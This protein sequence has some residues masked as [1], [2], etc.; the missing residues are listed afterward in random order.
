VTAAFDGWP[1]KLAQVAISADDP[2]AATLAEN[3]AHVSTASAVHWTLGVLQAE[4]RPTSHRSRAPPRNLNHGRYR[5][6][7][8]IGWLAGCSLAHR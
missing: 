2:P 8:F 4:L 7:R 5:Q 6:T 1:R 3:S